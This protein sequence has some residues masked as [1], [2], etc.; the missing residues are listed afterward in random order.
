[1]TR[2][3][4]LC[5]SLFVPLWFAVVLALCFPLAVPQPQSVVFVPMTFLSS[6][7]GMNFVDIPELNWAGSYPLFWAV[8]LGCICGQMLFFRRR[9]WI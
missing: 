6:V 1:M 4:P 2:C 5:A 8:V 9:G 3:R 7:Y